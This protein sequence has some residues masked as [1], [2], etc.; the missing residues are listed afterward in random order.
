MYQEIIDQLPEDQYTDAMLDDFDKKASEH[1]KSVDGSG[2][3]IREGMKLVPVDQECINNKTYGDFRTFRGQT[4]ARAMFLDYDSKKVVFVPEGRLNFYGNI[5]DPETGDRTDEVLQPEGGPAD[6][7]RSAGGTASFKARV[8]A[9][10]KAFYG[11]KY[12]RK[13]CAY[14]LVKAP[15]KSP[16]EP[17]PWDDADKFVDGEV[18][19]FAGCDAAGNE[20]W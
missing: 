18:F 15:R 7:W 10:S 2:T 11:K 20:I 12:N 19:D 9:L 6:A 1:T 5:V 16:I 8:E 17:R 13:S 4:Y 14:I 3:G